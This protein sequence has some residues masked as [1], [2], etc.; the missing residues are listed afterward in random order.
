VRYL[1]LAIIHF[2][3]AALALSQ[4]SCIQA[5]PPKR[6]MVAN[7][8]LLQVPWE[9]AYFEATDRCPAIV[10]VRSFEDT[11]VVLHESGHHT[12]DA[13]GNGQPYK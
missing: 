5:G 7:Y 2:V 13:I 10:V 8:M 6:K 12:Y 9:G 4:M 1:I 11:D 3:V